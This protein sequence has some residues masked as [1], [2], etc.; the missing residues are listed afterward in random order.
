MLMPTACSLGVASVVAM[1]AGSVV[2]DV[3]LSRQDCCA[4]ASVL[5]GLGRPVFLGRST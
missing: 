1:F 4:V 5:R 2:E 3:C